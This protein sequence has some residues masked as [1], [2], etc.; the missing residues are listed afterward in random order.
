MNCSTVMAEGE[1]NKGRKGINKVMK[2]REKLLCYLSIVV[3]CLASIWNNS[4]ITCLADSNSEG[5]K[6]YVYVN[7]EIPEITLSQGETKEV[8]LELKANS[9]KNV[10]KITIGTKDTPFSVKG[11]PKLLRERTDGEVHSIGRESCLLKFTL[12]ANKSTENKTYHISIA[13]LAGNGSADLQTYTLVDTIPVTYQAEKEESGTGSLAVFNINCVSE[14]KSGESANVV[15][16][17]AN[18]G[19]GKATDI[20]VS[21]E[22]FEDTGIL[23]GDQGTTQK[24]SAMEPNSQK[25]LKFP[26][27]GSQNAVTGAKKLTISVS[28]KA[29]KDAASYETETESFYIQVQGKSTEEN[30]TNGKTPKLLISNVKQSVKAPVAGKRLE[31]SFCLENVGQGAAKNITV[32]PTGLTNAT[33]TPLDDNP[34]VYV[35]ALSAGESKVIKLRYRLSSQIEKGLSSIDYTIAYKDGNGADYTNTS[36]AYIRNIQAKKDK[37]SIGVPKLII[38]KYSTGN[39]SVKAGGEFTFAFDVVNTHNSLSADNIKVT[40]TSDD[41]GTFSVAKGSNSFY[42]PTIGAK[43][44]VHKDIPIK[45]KADCTS[46]AYP[47]KIGFEYEYEGM[48]KPKDSLSSGLTVSETLTIQVKEDSR[49]AL[50]NIL[51]GAH[52]ELINGEI[53]SVSFDFNN[54]GKSPVYNVEITIKG[55]FS[56]TKESLFIG[57]V[58]AGSG[59]S[60]EMEITPT[61]EGK[62][63]GVMIVTYEDSNGRVGKIKHRFTGEVMSAE[64]ISENVIK[65]EGNQQDSSVDKEK[66]GIVSVP[67]FI[68]LEAGIFLLAVFVVRKVVIRRYCIRELLEE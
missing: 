23:P 34:N 1:K 51:P 16:K 68:V 67:I 7:N 65:P 29:K 39:G 43:K 15:Y 5:G 20:K 54:H 60:H 18:M 41:A 66:K 33:F 62:A 47:L 22:G 6:W 21:C 42:I 37:A 64:D 61:V 24:I 28:Y 12:K 48:E 14:L 40:I 3:L 56:P 11:R 57:T 10:D 38:H 55:D 31:L 63:T 4:A 26:I 50:T 19:D 27:R 58:E 36:K 52:G 59:G 46:K 45:V 25:K 13:F 35:K 17:L 32:T 53:N 49:P 2:T 44:S 8:T 30:K 9:T